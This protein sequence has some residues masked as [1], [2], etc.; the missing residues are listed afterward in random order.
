MHELPGVLQLHILQLLDHAALH[1][2][3]QVSTS[4]LA[5]VRQHELWRHL[6]DTCVA[7]GN[8]YNLAHNWKTLAC[9]AQCPSMANQHLLSGIQSFSSADRPS[10]SPANT[11][12]HSH[13]WMALQMAT[14][15]DA[16]DA[17]RTGERLQ[18][19]CGCSVGDSCYWSSSVSTNPN[20]NEFIEYTFQHPCVVSAVQIVP[21][22]V[23]WHPQSPTYAPKRVHFAF[24]DEKSIR[25]QDVL[26]WRL[27]PFFATGEFVVENEMKLQEFSLGQKVA[28]GTKTIMRVTL[29]GRQQAQTFVLPQTFPN[30]NEH[31]KYY[32]CLS[33]V[34]VCGVRWKDQKTANVALAT[35]SAMTSNLRVAAL[36]GLAVYFTACYKGLIGQSQRWE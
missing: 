10:E 24:Y 8:T 5:L 6:V 14:M 2:A 17:I 3:E 11:L 28:I 36:T 18:H 22:R 30:E 23:F 9:V 25:P 34:N 7:Y 19:C 12:T 20:A 21:Y 4:F 15:D 33:Y 26:K 1:A 16:N 32:C 13:C 29:M 27:E 35:S 31:P